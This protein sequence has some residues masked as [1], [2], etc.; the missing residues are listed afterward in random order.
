MS[1]CKIENVN[2]ALEETFTGVDS[3]FKM[4]AERKRTFVRDWLPAGIWMQS[5]KFLSG[6]ISLEFVPLSIICWYG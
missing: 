3:N 5:N 4:K 2:R 6:Y 1:C